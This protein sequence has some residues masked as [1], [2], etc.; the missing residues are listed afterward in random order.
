MLSFFLS[1]SAYHIISEIRVED[2]LIT[3]SGIDTILGSG[4]WIS[5]HWGPK[6]N[7]IP[8]KLT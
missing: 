4:K 5:I 3:T 1:F 6:T 8:I 2:Y 7:S